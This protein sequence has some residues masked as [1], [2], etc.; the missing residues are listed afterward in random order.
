MCERFTSVWFAPSRT[1]LVSRG[2]GSPSMSGR[3][4]PAGRTGSCRTGRQGLLGVARFGHHAGG[5]LVE[6]HGAQLARIAGPYPHRGGL[7]LF[8]PDHE[9][10]GVASTAGVPDLR[11]E[12]VA[13]DVEV[14]P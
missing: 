10:V 4:A 9:Q 8:R 7:R 6:L 11:P 13:R 1:G 14:D 5:E 3:P 2:S 12:L